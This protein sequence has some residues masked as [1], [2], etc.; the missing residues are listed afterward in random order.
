M[1][2]NLLITDDDEALRLSLGEAF[3]RRGFQVTLAADG[4]EALDVVHSA[5][6]HMALVDV[7]MPRV[8]GLQL[9]ERLRGDELEVPCILMSAALDESIRHEAESMHV[10]RILDKPFRL[11]DVAS[12]VRQGLAEHYG[13][14]G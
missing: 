11:A 13:W 10:F 4:Q 3:E 5:T 9:I 12:T 7:H 6:I 8:S 2:P 1:I 14:A